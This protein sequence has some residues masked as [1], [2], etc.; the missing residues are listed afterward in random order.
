MPTSDS[1]S[2][3]DF[4]AD[5]VSWELFLRG[6]KLPLQEKPFRVL[7]VLL[8][9]AGHVVSREELIQEFWPGPFAADDGLNTA[10][11]KI[12]QALCDGPK[13]PKYVETVG[14]RGY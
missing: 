1:I 13:R 5:L 2:F 3:G 9:N 8:R 10:V 11:R 6:Q 4:L 7:A 14:Q 12:R